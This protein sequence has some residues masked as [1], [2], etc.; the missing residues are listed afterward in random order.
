VDAELGIVVVTHNSAAVVGDLLDGLPAA[1]AGLSADVVVVDNG[2][3]DGTGELVARRTDCTLVLEQNRGYSAGL[4]R[5]LRT[6]RSAGPVLLLNP[7]VR[8]HPGSIPPLVAA[9]SRSRTGVVVP[10]LVD[11]TGRLAHS[12]RREPTLARAVGLGRTGRPALSEAVV[13]SAAYE[14]PGVADWATGAVMLLSRECYDAVGGWDESYFL[15]SEETDYC[16][17]ARDL[18]WSTRYEP[19]A[20]AVHIGAQSGQSPRIHAMQIVNRVRLFRRRHGPAASSLYL[21]LAVASE[22]SW[23]LRGSRRSPA[24]IRALLVPRWRPAELGCSDRLLPR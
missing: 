23:V 10:R 12:L 6:V 19:S 21:L 3:T 8:M 1:L 13:E 16:L 15:Y 7:D 5:G 24:A 22:A 11:D 20:T 14:S 18:G 9:L 4:N 17:R 2:S